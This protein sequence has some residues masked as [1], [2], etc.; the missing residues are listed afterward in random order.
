MPTRRYPWTVVD[1]AA[2]LTVVEMMSAKKLTL[3]DIV[4]LSYGQLR[5]SRIRDIKNAD[6]APIKISEFVLICEITDHSPLK[7][8][9]KVCQDARSIRYGYLTPEWPRSDGELRKPTREELTRPPMLE[10]QL[11]A[12]LAAV[13]ENPEQELRTI[14]KQ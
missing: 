11:I 9:A 8:F 2:V 7:M 14:E 3:H 4:K 12:Q 1:Y 13:R 10:D 5:Y 6:K